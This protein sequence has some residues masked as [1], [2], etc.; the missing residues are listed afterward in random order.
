M[1]LPAEMM[2]G[3]L[4]ELTKIAQEEI[5]KP[6]PKW[7][8]I[9]KAG[10]LSAAGMTAGYGTGLLID[11]GLRRTIG[12]RY[13]SWTPDKKYKVLGPIGAGLGLAAAA[14]RHHASQQ[15]KKQVE[16]DE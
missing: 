12:K 3:L 5:K 1:A 9:A 10:L 13:A 6:E 11:E 8:R 14:A 7:K 4:D 2:D 15:Y 16:G